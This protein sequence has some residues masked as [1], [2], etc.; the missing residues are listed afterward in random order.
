MRSPSCLWGSLGV[1]DF[2]THPIVSGEDI[3]GFE[4]LVL[5][6]VLSVDTTH[7]LSHIPEEV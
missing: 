5:I 4:M 6:D 2:N 7:E 3:T 1:S